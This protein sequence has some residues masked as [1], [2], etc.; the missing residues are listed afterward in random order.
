M[1][2]SLAQ[3]GVKSFNRPEV[4]VKRDQRWPEDLGGYSLDAVVGFRF[5]PPTKDNKMMTYYQAKLKILESDNPSAVGRTYT[6]SLFLSSGGLYEDNDYQRVRS[7]AAACEHQEIEDAKFDCDKSL[8]D[9]V[10]MDAKGTLLSE[11]VKIKH[12]ATCRAKSGFDAKTGKQKTG[13][14]VFHDFFIAE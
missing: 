10:D 3:Y 11:A 12:K 7:F 2:A 8:Q 4:M 1:S 13:N 6:V 9:L 14:N 5:V